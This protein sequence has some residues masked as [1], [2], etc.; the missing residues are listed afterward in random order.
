MSEGMTPESAA[1]SLLRYIAWAEGKELALQGG[2]AGAPS[3]EWIL[4]TYAQ[5][6]ALTASKSHLSTVLQVKVPEK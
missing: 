1:M 6:L 5:C 4:T 2:N 3:R